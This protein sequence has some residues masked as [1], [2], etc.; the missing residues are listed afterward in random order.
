VRYWGHY[1]P[2]S[3]MTESSFRKL[4]L[5][6]AY[7]PIL[8][9]C[10]FLIILGLQIR[11]IALLRI[12]GSQATT[13]LLQSDRLQKSLNDEETGVRG[14][15]ATRNPV[16]LQP[17]NEALGRF[18]GE[19]ASL[20]QMASSN[21]T[22]S[23]KLTTLSESSKRFD[24]IN[25][26]L[27]QTGLSN[28]VIVDLLLQQ[29]QVMDTLRVELADLNSRQN[30]IRESTRHRLTRAL[31]RL[32][33]ISAACGVLITILLLWYGIILFRAIT[34]AFRR[35]L[36]ETGL[37][38][39]SLHTTLQSIGDAVMVCDASGNIT[40][41]NP[42]AEH[43]TGWTTDEAVGRPLPEV[44][45]I[46]N[47]NT[48]L[49]VESP[50]DKVRRL[51]AAVILENHTV[52]IRKD[53]TEIPI[54]DSGAPIR[55]RDGSLSGVVL[56]FRSVAERRQAANLLRQNQERLDAIYNTT[57]TY[58]GI[59]SPEGKI[60]D[61]NRASLEFSGN[62]RDE[63]VGHY[64]WEGPWFL[65]TPGMPELVRAAIDHALAGQSTRTQLA[66]IR[67]N[68]ET[69][70][71]DFSLTPV[72][73]S[74]GKVIYLVPEGR[75][76]SE[77]KRAELALMQSEKLAAVGRLASSIAHEINNPLE[78]VTN[79]LFLAR[80]HSSSPETAEYLKSADHELRRVSVIANQTLRFHRQASSPQPVQP[81]DLFST[82]LSIYEGKLRNSNISV[83]ISHSTQ[84]AIVCFA[85]DI[86]Q[87]LNNLVG[88]AID[89]MNKQGGRLLI[90]S[91][92][93]TDWQTNRKG[94]V[95]TVADNGYGIA[96]KDL[97]Q[98]FEPFFTTK[99]IGGTGLG[100]WVSKEVVTRHKGTLRVRSRNAPN[101]S[102]TVFRFFLPFS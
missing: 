93:S 62:T 5:R 100:L 67:P 28:D 16:F 29:K 80:N 84:E 73:D 72:V 34:A 9:L 55:N 50:A 47:E 90:R 19:F 35:Q 40:M 63:V 65:Y 71:F 7:I 51:N 36:D 97:P 94:I 59:L 48:R 64:F 26:K 39:D 68:G 49:P 66:L 96:Q 37:Q 88:N 54:D 58:V 14:Y 12:A 4:L 31:S 89:A 30:D 43:L 20:Q 60:L 2:G 21:P 18:S 61:C 24:D 41:L 74:E 57:L 85:G 75:D 99:G 23:A 3:R 32:P 83:E 86:R 1:L 17:Y 56:V 98:I 70:H 27:L 92:V 25:R 45:H 87:V 46:I 78:A 42:T 53:R 52:L 44:F 82:V 77:L 95:F 102:G 81:V 79:L 38:R 69:I 8:T 15:L 101:C 10:G 11:E 76:I 22:L 33:I 91:V 6:L 13:I